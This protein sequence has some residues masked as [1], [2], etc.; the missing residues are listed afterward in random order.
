MTL[1]LLVLA[2]GW[3]RVGLTQPAIVYLD[4]SE[5]RIVMFTTAIKGG[6]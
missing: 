2:S 6:T 5:L 1:L 3:S 4:K